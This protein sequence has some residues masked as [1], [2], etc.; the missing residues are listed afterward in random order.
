VIDYNENCWDWVSESSMLKVGDDISTNIF[1][2]RVSLDVAL[3]SAMETI[4]TTNRILSRTSAI[5]VPMESLAVVKLD[6]SFHILKI[7]PIHEAL[8]IQK[9]RKLYE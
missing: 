5:K 9:L 8:R 4:N 3:Y 2:K 7:M 1:I 6:E